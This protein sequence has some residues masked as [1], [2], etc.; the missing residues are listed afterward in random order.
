MT[1]KWIG[2]LRN[3]GS[4]YELAPGYPLADGATYELRLQEQSGGQQFRRHLI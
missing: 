3:V 1:S 2:V 4:P